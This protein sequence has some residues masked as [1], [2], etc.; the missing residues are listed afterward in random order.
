M[1][2]ST[3]RTP[4]D[5]G[6]IEVYVEVVVVDASM[7]EGVIYMTLVLVLEAREGNVEVIN[8]VDAGPVT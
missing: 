2:S 3:G 4:K 7:G 6:M 8:M 1:V 5:V